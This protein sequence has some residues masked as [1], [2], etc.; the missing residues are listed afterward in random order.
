MAVIAERTPGTALSAASVSVVETLASV[1]AKA[2]LAT[3]DN[4]IIMAVV[5]ARPMLRMV[6][7]LPGKT[8]GCPVLRVAAF[9]PKEA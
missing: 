2:T 5:V 9:S 4:A 1:S 8:R 6:A 3:P 7:E